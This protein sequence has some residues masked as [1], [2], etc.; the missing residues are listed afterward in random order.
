M[1]NAAQEVFHVPFGLVVLRCYADT[2]Q[3]FVHCSH[4]PVNGHLIV[5]QDDNEIL[6][7]IARVIQRL[8]GFATGQRTI[9]KHRNNLVLA[10][11]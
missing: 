5:I 10:A 11:R 9:A 4:V 1:R 7:E 6:A 8:K 3:V 2:R